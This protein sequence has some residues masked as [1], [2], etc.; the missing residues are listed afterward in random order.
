MVHQHKY[1]EIILSSS[2]LIKDVISRD[3]GIFNRALGRILRQF[4]S[5][6]L[7]I[8]MEHL[9]TVCLP[10][11]RS[12][13]WT[14]RTNTITTLTKI[15]ISYHYGLKKILCFPKYF[16][17]HYVYNVLKSLK[18]EPVIN[19]QHLQ[20][21]NNMK[22]RKSPCLVGLMLYFWGR[23]QCF[24]ILVFSR[25]YHW[26]LVSIPRRLEVQINPNVA[27]QVKYTVK[28]SACQI[29]ERM[30][31]KY[32]LVSEGWP[33]IFALKF[34]LRVIRTSVSQRIAKYEGNPEFQWKPSINI[35]IF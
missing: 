2:G 17:N 31:I 8:K 20:T 28:T 4:H 35:D 16:I 29:N 26:L 25:S 30:C 14:T 10:I 1:L 7:G 32:A 19:L 24:I 33:Y 5:V 21:Y 9:K 15:A 27:D 12:G 34:E 23:M 3:Q 13:L 6:N 11:Y 22:G 18:F